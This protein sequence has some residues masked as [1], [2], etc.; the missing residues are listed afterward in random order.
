MRRAP[1]GKRKR[2]IL[3]ARHG[4]VFDLFHGRPCERAKNPR[5][6]HFYDSTRGLL[7]A[8]CLFGNGDQEALA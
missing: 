5:V 1:S 7:L 2:P 3:A 6:L 4:R 8:H